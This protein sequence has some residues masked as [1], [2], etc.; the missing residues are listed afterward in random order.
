VRH[1]DAEG[2]LTELTSLGPDDQLMNDEFGNAIL[3]ITK[4]DQFGNELEAV[5]MDPSEKH[6]HHGRL[7][8]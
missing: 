5:A 6:H 8:V 2:R 3:R 1:Y 7:V 4:T